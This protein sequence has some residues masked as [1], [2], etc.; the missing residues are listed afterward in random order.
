M[1]QGK[2][3]VVSGP[4][5]VGKSTVIADVLK[6]IPDLYFSVSFTTRPPRPGEKDGVHYH[7]VDDAEFKRMISD[8]ELLEYAQYVDHYYG[9]SEK[10]IDE[11]LAKGEDVLLDIEVQGAAIVR[12]KRPDA[13][14]VFVMPPSFD[15]L[16]ERLRERG[17][18]DEK[19]IE[20]RLKQAKKECREASKYA[21]LI[22][23][24]TVPQAVSDLEIVI[25]SE[26]KK[27]EEEEKEA[28][29]VPVRKDEN[30]EEDD[31]NAESVDG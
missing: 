9:T 23:N 26:R 11:H 8:G 31:Q 16:A 10:L 20:K 29:R 18:D 12:E 15:D 28:G 24:R 19:T 14:F 30:E 7:F 22:V 5:G 2:L 17:T 1:E 3:F 13:I 25:R 21:Y 6:D 4:S 27:A